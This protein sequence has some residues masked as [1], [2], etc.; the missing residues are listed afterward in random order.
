M[1]LKKLA[2]KLLTIIAVVCI[3]AY[4]LSAAPLTTDAYWK[5]LLHFEGAHSRVTADEFFL[6]I[7]GKNN[8]TA[9]L[10]ETIRLLDSKDGFE[11]ACNFPARYRWIRSTKKGVADFDLN[12]CVE[13]QNFLKSFQKETLSI[14]FVSEFID[15][16]ASAFGHIMLVFK[17][18]NSPLPLADTIHFAAVTEHEDFL[19]YAYRGLTGGYDGFFIRQPLFEKQYEYNITEQ[20]AL[21]FYK[22]NFSEEEISRI[23]F[24]LYELRKARFNYYFVD[25]NCAFYIGQLLD[26]AF[27]NEDLGFQQS[28]IV[29]P[30]DVVRKYAD[31]IVARSTFAPSL[32]KAENLIGNLSAQEQQKISDIIHQQ[33]N[34]NNQLSDQVKETLALHYQY[35]FRRQ[36]VAY[37]NFQTVESLQYHPSSF[38]SN[39]TNPLDEKNSGR[40]LLGVHSSRNLTSTIIGYRPMQRDIYAPQQN[41]LQ[42]SE[43]SV[44][45]IQTVVND[46]TF[47]LDQANLINLRSLPKRSVLRKDLS[48][49]F[50]A[51]FNR[52][53]TEQILR[54]EIE[55]GLGESIGSQ[56]WT[57]GWG[58]S[59]GAQKN[60]GI[61]AY[62]KPNL[63]LL[64]YLPVDIKVGYLTYAQHFKG[65]HYLQNELFVSKKIS[66]S[67]TTMKLIN[68]GNNEVQFIANFSWAI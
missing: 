42:E 62:L 6:S 24:H 27:E 61:N 28:K 18:S 52:K 63:V 16:P 1:K 15:V 68:L 46:Q 58:I 21:H 53:N 48:W 9:E 40:V 51:G 3:N 36:R 37:D 41:Y 38:T 45:D 56:N 47:N 2:I 67:Y 7:N 23:I 43:L 64:T 17:N 5:K 14:V 30:I 13:L 31:R 25:E 33:D 32:L 66:S 4:S 57:A 54:P 44:F 12:R 20:R 49:N 60:S 29:L 11:I 10:I 22:L 65:E 34:P 39:L 59:L 35:T 50:Y 26:T 19:K 8:A 55:F